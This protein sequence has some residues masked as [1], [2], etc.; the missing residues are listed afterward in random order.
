MQALACLRCQKQA[1]A[2]T[3]TQGLYWLSLALSSAAARPAFFL[4]SPLAR[5]HT[6]LNVLAA[7]ARCHAVPLHQPEAD[8]TISSLKLP[9][10]EMILDIASYKGIKKLIKYIK[11]TMPL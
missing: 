5:R 2:C 4:A 8:K 9:L 10:E 7:I 3:P 1:K 6:S 11:V